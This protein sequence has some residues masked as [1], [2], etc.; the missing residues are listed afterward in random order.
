MWYLFYSI[1]F[2]HKDFICQILKF[3]DLYLYINYLSNLWKMSLSCGCLK[4]CFCSGLVCL[5]LGKRSPKQHLGS[6]GHSNWLC[7]PDDLGLQFFCWVIWD[8]QCCCKQGQGLLLVGLTNYMQCQGWN[9][10]PLYINQVACFEFLVTL[11]CVI[12]MC[13]C[14]V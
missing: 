9:W 1:Q 8:C 6:L 4:L 12:C 7:R 5:Y 10:G 14:V 2:N 3:H 13:M 11:L